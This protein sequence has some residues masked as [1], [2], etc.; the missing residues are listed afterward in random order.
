MSR[1]E[2]PLRA[3]CELSQIPPAHHID[4]LSCLL[5]K[6]VVRDSPLFAVA[7]VEQF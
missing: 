4:L 6:Q 2:T 3:A 5:L 1:H 7:V